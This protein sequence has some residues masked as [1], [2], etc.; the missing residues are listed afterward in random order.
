M[1]IAMVASWETFLKDPKSTLGHLA[2]QALD[3]GSGG[4]EFSFS[5]P[6]PAQKR[7]SVETPH[8]LFSGPENIATQECA[9]IY[10][11]I[12]KRRVIGRSRTVPASINLTSADVARHRRPV[13]IPGDVRAYE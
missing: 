2:F 12:L 9:D 7:I 11:L 10:Y 6:D 3:H 13:K 4:L 1:A 8:D 5:G